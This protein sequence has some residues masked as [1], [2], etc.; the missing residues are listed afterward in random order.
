MIYDG[1]TTKP[2][3]DELYHEK[4]HKYVERHKG[5]KGN[6][7]YTYHKKATDT[8]KKYRDKSMKYIK[9]DDPYANMGVEERFALKAGVKLAQLTLKGAD[10]TK[11]AIKKMKHNSRYG[12]YTKNRRV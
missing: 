9:S 5:P 10:K 1:I 4:A 12:K 2:P 8:I 6:W 11:K 7:I 3:L